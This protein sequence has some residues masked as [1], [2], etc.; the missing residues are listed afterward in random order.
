MAIDITISWQKKS[1]SLK[2]I[3]IIGISQAATADIKLDDPMISR[4]H[5]R[6]SN[7]VLFICWGIPYFK[8]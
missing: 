2:D 1:Y 6:I 8:L 5:A 3:A 4:H 7:F